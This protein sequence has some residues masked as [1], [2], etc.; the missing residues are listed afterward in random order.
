M[1]PET[2]GLT[3]SSLVLGKHSGKHAFNEKLKELGYNLGDNAIVMEL[4]WSF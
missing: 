1:T 3:K 2:V 4:I